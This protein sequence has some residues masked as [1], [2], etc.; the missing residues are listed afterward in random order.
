MTMQ[1]EQHCV[2]LGQPGLN[3]ED[4]ARPNHG[5]GEKGFTPSGHGQPGPVGRQYRTERAQKRRDA[6]DRHIRAR[7]LDAECLGYAHACCLHPV[8]AHGF[9]VARLALETD[10]DEITG[11]QHLLR[12]LRCSAV[13]RDPSAGGR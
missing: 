12:R 1:R 9:L 5:S 13:R 4:Q 6:I 2:G 11:L 3:H 10:I 8:D 7:I